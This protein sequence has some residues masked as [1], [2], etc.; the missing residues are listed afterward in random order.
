MDTIKHGSLSR[1]WEMPA[2]AAEVPAPVKTSRGLNPTTRA[3]ARTNAES[4][5]LASQRMQALVG[6][7]TRLAQCRTPYDVFME[8]ARFMRLANEQYASAMRNIQAVWSPII[9]FAAMWP[10]ATPSVVPA[11]PH[12]IT[13]TLTAVPASVRQSQER[14]LITFRDQPLPE[15]EREAA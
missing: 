2:E 8:Q 15:R 1:W 13:R 5:A 6:M 3:I 12:S 7:P 10:I 11:L 9:P 14:D 4:V